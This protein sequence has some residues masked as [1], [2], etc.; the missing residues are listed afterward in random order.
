MKKFLLFL[1]VI[2]CILARA[3][4][5]SK[6]VLTSPIAYRIDSRPIKC[7]PELTCTSPSLATFYQNRQHAFAWVKNGELTL[8]GEALVRAIRRAYIDGLDPRAYHVNQINKMVA[9]LNSGDI[10]VSLD[11]ELTLTDGLFLYLNNL[12][13]GLQNG[14][15]LYPGWPIASKYVDLQEVA[16]RIAKTDDIDEILLSI[17]PKYPGYAMLRE[18]LSDYYR[19]ASKGGWEPIPLGA[20]SLKKGSKGK[21]VAL[22]QRRLYLSGEL[23]DDDTSGEFDKDLQQAVIKYQKDNGLTEDG[24]VNKQTL[25]SLNIPIEKRIRQI[26]LNMDRMRFLPDDR[27]SRYVQVNI[28]SYTLEAFENGKLE[29]FSGVVVGKPNKRT[30][31]LNSQIARAEINPYWNIPPSIVKEILPD[32]KADP[33]YLAENGIK[34]FN[35]ESGGR[36]TNVDPRGINWEDPSVLNLKFREDPGEDNALGRFKFIFDNKCGIYLHDSIAQA[37]FDETRR[38]LSHGCIRI[39]EVD[40]FANYLL[41]PNGWDSN[42]VSAEVDS[43]KHQFVKLTTPTQLYVIYLTAWYDVD[44]GSMQF[45]DDIY[46]YDKLSAYPFYLSQD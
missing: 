7:A 33:N 26:A 2:C 11:L 10:A 6:N 32:I 40:D 22:L 15:T 34:V 45:R 8:P 41:K 23:S 9:K 43:K 20:E 18:K 37:A 16:G 12:V 24:V 30:C 4:E 21:R 27:P 17:A 35:V 38:G 36:Y 25:N 3:D 46:H 39:A 5:V 31:V 28:P 42:K 44:E 1:G 14:K 19:I 29:V 13:Y